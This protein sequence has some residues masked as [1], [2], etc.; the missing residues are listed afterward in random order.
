MESSYPSF[1]L[2]Y[3]ELLLLNVGLISSK[4]DSLILELLALEVGGLST[5]IL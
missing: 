2:L 4:L 1:S 5:Q 3:K